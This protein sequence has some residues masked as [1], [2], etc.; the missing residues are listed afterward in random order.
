MTDWLTMITEFIGMT[1]AMSIFGLP[2]WLTVLGCWLIMGGMILSGRYW[3][4][5]KIALLAGTVVLIPNAPLVL[6]TLFV[7]VIA[8]TLLPAALV[9]LILLL[10]DKKTMGGYVNTTWENIVNISIVIAIIVM[11]TLYGTSALFPRIATD[12]VGVFWD[13]LAALSALAALMVLGLPTL[14]LLV[15]LLAALVAG[16]WWSRPIIVAL[17]RRLMRGIARIPA[18]EMF[19]ALSAA[20]GRTW[21]G[22]L[23]RGLAAFWARTRLARFFRLTRDQVREVNRRYAKPE[24]ETTLFAKTCLVGLRVYLVLLVGLMVFKFM[25]AAFYG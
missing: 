10:N 14:A 24:I 20:A 13:M 12:P 2:P 23:R 6:I 16:L 25:S 9:F 4:W 22:R 11:S 19:R 21:V 15:A 1:A 5:E 3:T 18:R 8:T 17:G 7:Q